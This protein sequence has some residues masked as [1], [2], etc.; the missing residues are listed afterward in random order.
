MKKKIQTAALLAIALIMVA[1]GNKSEGNASQ[2]N[3][4]D[5]PSVEKKADTSAEEADATAEENEGDNNDILNIK[6][7]WKTKTINMGDDAVNPDIHKFAAVF[8]KTYPDYEPNTNLLEYLNQ[9]KAYNEEKTGFHINDQKGNGYISS[10]LMTECDFNTACCYWKRKDGHR[11][12]AFWL[13]KQLEN[14]DTPEHQ[15]LFYDFD[16]KTHVMTPEPQL[17][18][19]IEKNTASFSTYEVRLPDEGKDIE[20]MTYTDADEDSY[21][22]SSFQMIWD[23]QNFTIKK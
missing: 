17:T 10:I 15:V 9:P 3:T 2:E 8:C 18:E 7:V 5:Q 20:V 1:C 11:L 23:G 13:S 21:D 16:P 12:V 4:T 22:V 6:K 14:M 19:L